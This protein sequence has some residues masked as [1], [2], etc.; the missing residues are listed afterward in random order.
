MLLS[1]S[2]FDKNIKI[3]ADAITHAVVSTFCGI[4][5]NRAYK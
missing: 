4:R 3:M 5:I 2:L 1:Y